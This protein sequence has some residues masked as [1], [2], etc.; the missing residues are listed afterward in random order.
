[1]SRIIAVTNQKGGVG[2]T[3]TAINLCAYLACLDRKVL[4]VDCDPQG[5]TTGGLS[6]PREGSGIYEI[7]TG[8][9][10]AA[11]AVRP[12]GTPGLFV[13]PSSVALSGAEIEL[14]DMPERE[15]RLRGALEKVKGDYDYIFIDCPPSLGL[16]T[17]NALAAADS[18]L[19]P[20]QCEYFALEGVGLLMNTIRLIRR[21]INPDIAV[22][23]IVLTMTDMRT[24]LSNQVAE[25]VRK[26][27]PESLYSTSIPRN[28]R[29]SEAPSYGLPISEYDPK[30]AGAHAYESLA[31][32]FLSRNEE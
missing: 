22:E 4:L 6:V 13:I 24:N 30:C 25:E 5:N 2:K 18:V 7:L 11:A 19:I 29:L 31:L 23:G 27:F 1:M 32:E 15:M 20:I 21:R 12:T 10:E 8:D 16:I 26:H 14:V 9:A 3:T 28:V 17:V